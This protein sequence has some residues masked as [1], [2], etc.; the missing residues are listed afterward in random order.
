[1]GHHGNQFLSFGAVAAEF[2]SLYESFQDLTVLQKQHFIEWFSGK[3]LDLL[4]RKFQH[5]GVTTFSMVDGIDG[6]FQMDTDSAGVGYID[7]DDGTTLFRQYK[8]DASIAIF[9]CKTGGVTGAGHEIGLAGRRGDNALDAM[10]YSNVES[11]SFTRLRTGDA[12]TSTFTNSSVTRH[13][14]FTTIKLEAS[15]I[16]IKMTEDG[17]LEV[18]KTTNRPTAKMSPKFRNLGGSAANGISS[19]RYLE[20]FNT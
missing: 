8:H 20:A 2:A 10:F 6:G 12:S 13:D 16:D 19:I 4:W 17:V 7:F 11:Q 14:N 5:T 3:A 1:M 18:T 9:V 15:T